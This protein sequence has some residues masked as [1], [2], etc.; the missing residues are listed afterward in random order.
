MFIRKSRRISTLVSIFLMF[1]FLAIGNTIKKCDVKD[2]KLMWETTKIS[3]GKKASTDQAQAAAKRVFDCKTLVGLNREQ[4]IK[5]LG[6]PQKSNDSMYNFPFYPA[7]KQV[8]V[9]RFDTGGY[10]WQFNIYFDKNGK[11]SKVEAKGIE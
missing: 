9:Y 11:A 3:D 10:G 1:E 5:E 7:E 6:D 8:L 2:L 4:V